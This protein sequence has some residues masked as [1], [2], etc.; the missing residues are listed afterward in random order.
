MGVLTT[1][2]SIPP[3]IMKKIQAYKKHLEKIFHAVE[4]WRFDDYGFDKSWE[5]KIRIIGKCYPRTRNR[6]NH[7]NCWKYPDY[8]VWIVKPKDVKFAADDIANA[9]FVSLK[10]WCNIKGE[11]VRDYYG[12]PIPESLYDYYIGDLET[13]KTFLKK[14]ADDGNYLLFATG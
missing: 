6:L 1:A 5:E 13:F 4:G 2:Y 7:Q 14:A 11:F 9:S 8:D 12:N 10:K 3:E